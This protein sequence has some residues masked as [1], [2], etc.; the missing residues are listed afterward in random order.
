MAVAMAVAM[1]VVAMVVAMAAAGVAARAGVT[2]AAVRAEAV[3]VVAARAV[4]KGAEEKEGAAMEVGKV[5][6][7]RVEVERV[8]VEREVAR[9]EETVVEEKVAAPEVATAEE[10]KEAEAHRGYLSSPSDGFAW[11]ADLS[12]A[13]SDAPSFCRPSD[14]ASRLAV[15][16]I[17]SADAHIA[18]RREI[19]HSWL[20]SSPES[21][22]AAHF[23]LHGR[24]AHSL[25]LDEAVRHGDIVFLDGEAEMHRKQGPLAKLLLWMRCAAA[26]WPGALLVGKADDD[27]WVH[28]SGVARQLRA[29]LSG[30]GRYIY[31]GRTETF[32]WY[33]RAH[34]PAAF[35][36]RYGRGE[37]C[38]RRRVPL[39]EWERKH[40][41]LGYGAARS[42]PRADDEEEALVGPFEFAKGPLVF[43]SRPLAEQVASSRWVQREHAATLRSAN[44]STRESTWP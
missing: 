17:F 22:I 6:E 35:A 12:P 37:H 34:R 10:V 5:A 27:T 40:G 16:G 9:E 38:T 15:L 33:E 42:W 31:W 23:V 29:S 14:R 4:G 18:H 2:E 41:E 1:A 26:A 3:K 21:G 13:R 25:V 39:G 8:A 32:H 11:P 24:G 30:G 19:R 28:M 44:H 7:A 36:G 20:H 43:L